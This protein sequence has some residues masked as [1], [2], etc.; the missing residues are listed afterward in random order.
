MSFFEIVEIVAALIEM[1]CCGIDEG[2]FLGYTP[3]AWAARNGHGEVVE[4]LLRWEEVDQG[5]PARSGQTPF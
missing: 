3:L 5:K 2:D 4:I 1:E